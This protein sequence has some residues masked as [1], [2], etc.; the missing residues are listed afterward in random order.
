MT[1][2]LRDDTGGGYPFSGDVTRR[3]LLRR[4]GA[5]GVALAGSSLIAAC[6][7]DSSSGTGTEVKTS[8]VHGQKLADELH[9]SNWPY[10]VDEDRQSLKDF[11]AKTGVRVAYSEEINDNEQFYG[12]VRQQLSR[13]EDIG[14]D[15][16]VLTDGMAAKWVRLGYAE[17]LD[18][19]NIPT[20]RKNM[21][22][23]LRNPPFDPGRKYT[24]PWESGAT[25]IGTNRKVVGEDVTKIADL[26]EPELHG[27]VGMLTEM[28][29]CVGFV[30]LI[31]GKDPTTASL[32]DALGAIEF[33]QEQNDKGQ[34]RGFYG[35][36]WTEKLARGELG[37]TL[38]WPGEISQILPDNP[39]LS[40]NY[41]E[42]GAMLWSDN[43]IMPRGRP[44]ESYAAA[45]AM[46]NHVYDPH[47][48][49]VIDSFVQYIP[50]AKGTLEV[51]K[52]MDPKLAE[53]PLV[54]PDAA[55]MRKFHIFRQLDAG[56]ERQL[57]QAFQ[58]VLGA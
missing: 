42:E 34:I 44:N 13:G 54:F 25:G 22:E 46:M 32:D 19:A 51:M 21:V 4:T 30:L 58:R 27:R 9:F 55:T 14:R 12:K 29:D 7:V 52:K 26:F 23:S 50:P 2:P 41:P 16:V 3:T 10:Y 35:A 18:D 20:V 38:A 53:N 49:A 36:D 28:R 24:I 43:M 11:T 1:D 15:I 56:E 37:A 17:P 57:N 40:F 45:E 33:L 5:F 48:Q 31:Q 39:G 8:A 6:G 47:V